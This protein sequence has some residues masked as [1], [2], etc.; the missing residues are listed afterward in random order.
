MVSRYLDSF[1]SQGCVAFDFSRKYSKQ[2][3]AGGIVLLDILFLAGKA[4]TKIP[5]KVTLSALTALS[6]MGLVDTHT[7]ADLAWKTL[8]DVQSCYRSRSWFAGGVSGLKLI[9][10][11]SNFGLVFGG[12]TA[13]VSGFRHTE[14]EDEIYGQMV[15]W[16][17]ITL[18]ISILLEAC[19]IY[20][21]KSALNTIKKTSMEHFP[22][23]LL[24]LDSAKTEANLFGPLA[25]LI[26]CGMDKD[27]LRELIAAL[28][29]IRLDDDTVKEIVEVIQENIQTELKYDQ[30]AQLLFTI[31]GYVALGV[32]KYY[33]PN[34]LQ[35]ACIS[36]SFATGEA[37]ILFREAFKEAGQR[38]RI[39]VVLE[40][41]LKRQKDE[42]EWQCLVDEEFFEI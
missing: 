5:E 2:V 13:T 19:Y 23:I 10:I 28:Y 20:L 42:D 39:S 38:K 21:N 17:E 37:G 1:Y 31:A 34:S 41:I 35:S 4:T 24:S 32:E 15:L 7:E 8:K 27:T 29:L 16:G 36:L 11:L 18:L 25:S 22:E 30:I 26:R 6:F 9:E 40:R 3:Q 12:C 14:K 33:T